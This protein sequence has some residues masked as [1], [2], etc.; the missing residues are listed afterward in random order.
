MRSNK[1]RGL[2]G[3]HSNRCCDSPFI[4]KQA[5]ATPLGRSYV[6][7]ITPCTKRAWLIRG[8]LWPASD[9]AIP[10]RLS[11]SFVK[12]PSIFIKHIE[13]TRDLS[14]RD[15]AV[16]AKSTH[17]L[18]KT[19]IVGMAELFIEERPYTDSADMKSAMDHR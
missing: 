12:N 14:I 9:S 16:A 6:F 15:G 8:E 7:P 1:I 18:I 13:I 4:I 10:L 11:G 17:L 19:R 5:A 2:C 3:E